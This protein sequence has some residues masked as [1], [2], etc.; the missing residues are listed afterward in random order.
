M[1]DWRTLTGWI[2]TAVLAAIVVAGFVMGDRRP[3]DRVAS[4]GASI[5]CPVCQ[6]EAIVDSPSET[7][8][9]MVEIV[10]EKVAAGESD[11]QILS[12]FRARYGDAIILDPP[13]SGKTLLV[14]LLPLIAVGVGIWLIL[15]RRRPDHAEAP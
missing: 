3:E 13:F 12:Y 10:D 4:L 7:A 2:V 6:G 5:M 1:P 14:W 11:R 9:A 8:R 15:S